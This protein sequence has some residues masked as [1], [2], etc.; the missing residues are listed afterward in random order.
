MKLEVGMRKV[1]GARLKAKGIR[2]KAHRSMLKAQRRVGYN[3]FYCLFLNRIY[4]IRS[5]RAFF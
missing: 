2:G 3:P 1:K 5:L 4:R